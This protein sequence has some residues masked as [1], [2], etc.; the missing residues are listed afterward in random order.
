MK[1][2]L[3]IT[4]VILAAAAGGIYYAW[5]SSAIKQPQGFSHAQHVAQNID[6]AVCHGSAGEYTPLNEKC[7]TCHQGMN[8][9]ADVHWVKVYRTA[10]D[11]IFSH[12][13]HRSVECA[14]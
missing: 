3:I 11:I 14:E 10:P 2:A 1:K 5:W 13:S 12:V 6:C 4:A 8:L 7:D 9:P